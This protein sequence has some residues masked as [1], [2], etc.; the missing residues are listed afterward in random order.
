ML[1]QDLHL[2]KTKQWFELKDCSGESGEIP[3]LESIDGTPPK[4]AAIAT[5][6]DRPNLVQ[7]K[8][9]NNSTN[10]DNT[11]KKW[12]ELKECTGEADKVPLNKTPNGGTPTN[13]TWAT[14]KPKN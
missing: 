1:D 13:A 14:C 2:S 12:V 4:N 8:N 5:C 3:L 7:L 10:N 11:S 6:K 9:K